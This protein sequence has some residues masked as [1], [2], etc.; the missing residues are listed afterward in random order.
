MAHAHKEPSAVRIVTPEYAHANL[1]KCRTAILVGGQFRN[2]HHHP[3]RAT[4]ATV[5]DFAH[6]DIADTITSDIAT[7]SW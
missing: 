4:A 5:I 3:R 7:K 2:S 6:N 1:G